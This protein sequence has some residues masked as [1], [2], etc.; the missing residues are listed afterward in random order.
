MLCSYRCSEENA[1]LLTGVPYT[2]GK[3]QIVQIEF[4]GGR[5]TPT[6]FFLL[7]RCTRR[8]EK[9]AKVGEAQV[10]GN[11]GASPGGSILK[12]PNYF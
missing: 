3:A 11:L 12:E 2:E 7:C 1:E 8:A 9:H 4:T 10:K 5:G 6:L